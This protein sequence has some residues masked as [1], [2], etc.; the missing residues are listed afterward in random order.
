[1]A[2]KAD[3]GRSMAA[4]SLGELPSELSRG[5]PNGATL[6]ASWPGIHRLNT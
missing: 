3:E 6:L 1:M 2:S 5:Y 4:I